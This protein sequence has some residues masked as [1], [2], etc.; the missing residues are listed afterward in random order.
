[1]PAF[2]DIL[3]KRSLSRPVRYGISSRLAFP[4]TAP[5][6][7]LAALFESSAQVVQ[8]RE[9]GLPA[10]ANRG[11]VDKGAKL[12]RSAGKLLLVN[13]LTELSLEAGADGV[14]LTSEQKVEEAKSLRERKGI[15]E[16]LIGK[17]VHSVAEAVQA[18][19]DGADYVLLGPIF[20]PFSIPS[21]GPGL[22][23]EAVRKAAESLTVPVIALGGI[24]E[25]RFDQVVRAGAW[26]A[27]GITWFEREIEELLQRTA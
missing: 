17:S 24:D 21:K 6:R 2:S 12:A 14:H 5:E 26:G 8:W 7:Y 25:G 18:E 10:A 16:H 11:L 19:R 27:A 20:Q 4:S 23:L 1:L 22:G 3:E 15:R 13:S 9:K